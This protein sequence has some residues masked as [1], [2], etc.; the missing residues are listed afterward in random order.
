MDRRQVMQREDFANRY[1]AALPISLHELLYPLAQAYDSV[2]IERISRSGGRTRPSHPGRTRPAEGA[3]AGAADRSLYAAAG[4]P[5]R[6]HR[7]EQSLGNYVGIA[8]SPIRCLA[9]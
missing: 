6:R 4:R 1:A 2:C 9:N 7:N 3:Q 5:G 8:E